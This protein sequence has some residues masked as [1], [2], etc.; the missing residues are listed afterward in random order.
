[1]KLSP[2]KSKMKT[3][4]FSDS[5]HQMRDS[6]SPGKISSLRASPVNLSE[7]TNN[8]NATLDSETVE[9]MFLL[10]G[11]IRS[12]LVLTTTEKERESL[13]DV[14][15]MM[16]ITEHEV[17]SFIQ[18]NTK[19]YMYT[20]RHMHKM[21]VVSLE[22]DRSVEQRIKELIGKDASDCNYVVAGLQRE[23][24][25]LKRVD[26]DE[27]ESVRAESWNG[28]YEEQARRTCGCEE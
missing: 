9:E 18:R 26:P 16:N 28:H 8:V 4:R 5:E 3:I 1:M 14:S 6:G 2:Q 10:F 21:M 23:V 25:D 12:K 20:L 22:R 13:K 7:D 17:K 19:D 27:R 15:G 11:D 24:V